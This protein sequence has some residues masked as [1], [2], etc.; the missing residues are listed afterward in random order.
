M[1]LTPRPSVPVFVVLGAA[2]FG[3]GGAQSGRTLPCDAPP[4]RPVHHVQ[5]EEGQDPPPMP[6]PGPS[7]NEMCLL[8]D[9]QPETDEEFE[10]RTREC[11]A[12]APAF[13]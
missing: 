1:A 6:P 3:C 4:P 9:Y 5:L 13:E 11:C 2:A 8:P 12:H 7:W 10:R